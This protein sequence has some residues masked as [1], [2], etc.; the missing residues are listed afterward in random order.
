MTQT[1]PRPIGYM[2]K[3]YPRLSET[4]ILNEMRALERLGTHLHVFSLMRPEEA[5]S[6]HAVMELRAPVTYL[7]ETLTA[8]IRAVAR[9]HATMAWTVPGR[10]LQAAGL[11][12]L[13][14]LQ[15]RRPPTARR[16][17]G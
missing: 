7:P 13:W 16:P 2:L 1:P 11:A 8:K 12:L 15:S 5:L 9:A 4:F 10:Y 17:R 6:H 14:S 3:R